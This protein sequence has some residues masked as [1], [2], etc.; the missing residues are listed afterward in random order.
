MSRNP[1]ISRHK[2]HT[3]L[4]NFVQVDN[5]KYVHYF[6]VKV[7]VKK[8]TKTKSLSNWAQVKRLKG[9]I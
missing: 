2:G 4:Q 9:E 5:D 3:H 8:K 6:K 7:K 1:K